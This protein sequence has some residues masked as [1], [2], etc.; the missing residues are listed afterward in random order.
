MENKGV[1]W[2]D[3]DPQ[4]V[5]GADYSSASGFRRITLQVTPSEQG[6]DGGG[7]SV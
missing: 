7:W 2:E 1:Y 6:S 5:L 4:E 3:V